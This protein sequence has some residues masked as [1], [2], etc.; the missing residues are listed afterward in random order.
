M[1]IL[2]S[3]EY[4]GDSNGAISIYAIQRLSSQAL[5]FHFLD[6]FFQP[7][8]NLSSYYICLTLSLN[9]NGIIATTSNICFG[10]GQGFST[11]NFTSAFDVIPSYMANETVV[12]FPITMVGVIGEQ[13]TLAVNLVLTSVDIEGVSISYQSA[14][15]ILFTPC[16][17]DQ[18][19]L[20]FPPDSTEFIGCGEPI[21]LGAFSIT[22]HALLSTCNWLVACVTIATGIYLIRYSHHSV[23]KSGSV[24]MQ[25]VILTG[26]LFFHICV[27]LMLIQPVTS[28]SCEAL[29]YF[30][31]LGFV[32]CFCSI[33]LKTWRIVKIFTQA[34]IKVVIIGNRYIA[35]VLLANVGLATL[36]NIIRSFVNP[37]SPH[38]A[39]I[40]SQLYAFCDVN[41]SIEQA[42]WLWLWFPIILEAC[43][44]LYT[45]VLAYNVKDAPS[46]FNESKSLGI[47]VYN[48]AVCAAIV[49]NF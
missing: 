1:G 22:A 36:F 13:Y 45:A 8:H 37:S 10:H 43:V 24:P 38:H 3:V 29:L 19:Q 14:L 12:L 47:T 31:H 27:E 21:A 41:R 18:P 7:T 44:L 28:F 34:K 11:V 9:R 32:C 30:G 5:S 23:F 33:T 6:S 40:G 35:L 2:G 46:E 26:F 20:P 39:I 15:S 16:Q 4:S 25:I 49:T 42:A 48:T 17:S